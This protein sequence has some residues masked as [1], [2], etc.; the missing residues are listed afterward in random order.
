MS[1]IEYPNKT[2]VADFYYDGFFKTHNIII[3]A[4]KDEET[5]SDYIYQKFSVKPK[6]TWLMNCNYQ[7]VYD[8]NGNA[9]NVQAKILYKTSNKIK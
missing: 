1:T 2:F 9:D 6:L 4:A 7:T 5:A 3:I 8:Q